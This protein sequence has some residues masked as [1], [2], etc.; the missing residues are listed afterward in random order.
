MGNDKE[1]KHKSW[2]IFCTTCGRLADADSCVGRRCDKCRALTIDEAVD[3]L[4]LRLGSKDA[5]V[6]TCDKQGVCADCQSK[7]VIE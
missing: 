2:R 4:N 3:I 6:N 5:K 7:G 1:S